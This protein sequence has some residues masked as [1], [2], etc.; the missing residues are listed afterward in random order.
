[1][2][3]WVGMVVVVVVCGGMVGWWLIVKKPL[4]MLK[5]AWVF[6]LSPV[7]PAKAGTSA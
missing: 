4:S 1:L 5:G 7:M 3:D 2:G 6:K